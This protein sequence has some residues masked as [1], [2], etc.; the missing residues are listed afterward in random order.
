MDV[1]IRPFAEEMKSRRR[2]QLLSRSFSVA[3]GFV[4]IGLVVL[5]FC[6]PVSR[7]SRIELSGGVNIKS[8]HLR[9]ILAL[10]S[11]RGDLILTYDT[12][13]A[14]KLLENYP[15]ID[16]AS[17]SVTPFSLRVAVREITPLCRLADGTVYY[18][19]GEVK[20]SYKGQ[21][22]DGNPAHELF[23]SI[24][25]AAE[26]DIPEFVPSGLTDAECREFLTELAGFKRQTLTA[27]DRLMPF[28]GS[29]KAYLFFVDSPSYDFAYGFK[30][31]VD[32]LSVI[33][34]ATLE[35]AIGNL[36]VKFAGGT[37][38]LNYLDS[39]K[40]NDE[41]FS[42][43]EVSYSHDKNIFYLSGGSHA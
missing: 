31:L 10:D 16:T 21:D 42:Y 11:H 40:I 8:D 24:V 4:L 26:V 34:A 20:E 36:E 33:S 39:V 29:P 9:R 30:V 25:E 37:D 5:Y 18:S 2:R 14:E 22:G 32:D 12:A 3:A 13:K 43:V 19:D 1:E 23:R 27:I 38:Y 7:L 17:V 35:L 6:T 15:L 41:D 28:D